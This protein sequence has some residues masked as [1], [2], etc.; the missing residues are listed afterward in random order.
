PQEGGATRRLPGAPAGVGGGR[1]H[2]GLTAGQRGQQGIDDRGHGP[3]GPG[4]AEGEAPDG[5][6]HRRLEGAS[7]AEQVGRGPEYG[8][9]LQA[10]ADVVC[11]RRYGAGPLQVPATLLDLGRAGGGRL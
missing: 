2:G 10:D 11:L 6:A 1:P 7:R 4:S 8:G 3:V 5:G 9:D